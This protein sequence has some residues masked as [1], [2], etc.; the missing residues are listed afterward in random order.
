MHCC[1]PI[2]LAPF[3]LPVLASDGE[4]YDAPALLAAMAADRWHRSPVTGAVL[5]KWAYGNAVVAAALGLPGVP[6]TPLPLWADADAPSPDKAIT[7]TVHHV[8]DVLVKRA[9]G[10]GPW[11]VT[12][13]VMRDACSGVD[14]GMAPP[15]G[16]PGAAADMAALAAFLGVGPSLAVGLPN[17][18]WDDGPATAE[19]VWAQNRCHNAVIAP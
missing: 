11:R 6:M 13:P 10:A 14:Y 15:L 8:N 4:T 1:C 7:W 16:V 5:R 17:A 12:L 19:T 9:F 2:T 3:T 18:V